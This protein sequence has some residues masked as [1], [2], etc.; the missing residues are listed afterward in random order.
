[1]VSSLVDANMG[2]VLVNGT[3]V[4]F[5]NNRVRLFALA[6]TI[7]R[8]RFPQYCKCAQLALANSNSKTGSVQ[9]GGSSLYAVCASV[10]SSCAVVLQLVVLTFFLFSF[11]CACLAF[12][13][14]IVFFSSLLGR[15]CR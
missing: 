3:A 7:R 14:V 10:Q 6:S 8:F 5:Q 1:M 15:S 9:I 2:N 12:L 4:L 11:I 13:S